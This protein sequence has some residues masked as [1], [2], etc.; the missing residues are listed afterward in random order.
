[1]RRTLTLATLFASLSLLTAA[2]PC[3]SGLPPGKRPGP[4]AFTV[5]T[6]P[7]RGQPTCY[8]CETAY[9]PAV[10]VFARRPTDTLG[11]LVGS[12]DKAV[13]EHAKEELRAWVTVLDDGKPD[14]EDRVTKWGQ[15]HAVRKVP[16]GVFED[17]DGPPSYQLNREADVTVVMFVKNRVV[18]NFAFR[19]DELDDSGRTRVLEALPQ[20]FAAK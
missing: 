3:S 6:G 1:M 2:E 8:I 16:I 15:T 13:A 7:Q 12:L 11:K 5:C 14:L 4:Y 20:L 18:A 10:V 9:R 19:A 17:A